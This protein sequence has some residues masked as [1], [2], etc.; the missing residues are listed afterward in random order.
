M[1]KVSQL[2]DDFKMKN[3]K[4]DPYGM[5]EMGMDQDQMEEYD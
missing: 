2:H 1:K 3:F 5:E 4:G